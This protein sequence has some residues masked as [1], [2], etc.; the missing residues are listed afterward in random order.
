MCVCHYVLVGTPPVVGGVQVTVSWSHRW[1]GYCHVPARPGKAGE[2]GRGGK[3]AGRGKGIKY[4]DCVFRILII[5]CCITENAIH[6][7]YEVELNKY[8]LYSMTN[9]GQDAKLKVFF[10]FYKCNFFDEIL[11]KH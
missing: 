3:E 5:S 11:Y 4:G 7:D 2:E 9:H 1:T 10:F 6:K 8:S